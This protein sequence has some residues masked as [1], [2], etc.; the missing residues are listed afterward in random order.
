MNP[1]IKT[2]VSGIDAAGDAIWLAVCPE[3]KIKR[4]HAVERHAKS[5]IAVHRRLEHG[6]VGAHSRSFQG[7]EAHQQRMASAARDEQYDRSARSIL[8]R[9]AKTK[10]FDATGLVA[11]LAL[12]RRASSA[13]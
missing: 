8:D 1:A 5:G 13:T 9:S 12:G 4:P 7:F 6:I 10:I 11:L 3:C 2:Y